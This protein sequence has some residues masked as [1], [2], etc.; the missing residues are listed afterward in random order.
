MQI[1]FVLK[2]RKISLLGGKT[3][4]TRRWGHV[5]AGSKWRSRCMPAAGGATQPP[6]KRRATSISP[7]PQTLTFPSNDK[8]HFGQS[9]SLA[10]NTQAQRVPP[11]TTEARMR[12]TAHFKLMGVQ[13]DT[14]LVTNGGLPHRA[15]VYPGI[16]FGGGV[17]QIQS[18]T[19]RTGIWGR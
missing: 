13:G 8:R 6:D 5:Q 1:N 9:L 4:S 14:Q 11:F 17:Q 16:L 15:E 12:S 3:P 2:I 10:C 18:R 19:E 7:I